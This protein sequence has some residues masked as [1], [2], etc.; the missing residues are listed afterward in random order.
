MAATPKILFQ[1]GASNV[2]FTDRRDFYPEAEVYEYW[3]NTT[4]FLTWISMIERKQTPDTLFKIFEDSPTFQNQYFYNNSATVTAD[5]AATQSSAIAVDNITNLTQAGTVDA[6]MVGLLCEVWD[7]TGT[8]KKGQC[9]IS[10]VGSGTVYIKTTKALAIA[11]VDNDIFRVIGTVRGELSVAGESYFNE[12]TVAWNSTHFLS[13]PVEITGKL[14]RETKLRGF[15]NELG[16]LR[17]KKFKE[18]KMQVQNGFLKSS[19]FVG[20]NLGGSDTFSEASLGTITDSASNTSSVRTTYGYIPIL[21]DYGITW[22]GGGAMNANTN[23]FKIPIASL[24]FPVFCDMSKIIHDKREQSVIPGFCGY[25]F[26]GEIAKALADKKFGFLGKVELENQK[27]N[28]LGW[29]VRN[30]FTPFGTIQLIMTKAFANEYEY[31]CVLPNEQA[32]GIREYEPWQYL[33][34][35]KTDNNYTGVKDV[36]NYDAGLQM[37]LLKTHHMIQFIV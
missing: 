7:S 10:A 5:N 20:T 25:G 19:S 28:S 32:I 18:M 21:E 29:D 6:S 16:R 11:T 33:T 14:Y 13:L 26:V 9:Y 8:T 23:I 35:I 17:E 30:L 36:I 34:N 22:S 2:L 1:G 15:A 12:L 4:Q 24:D 3:K 27:V 37:N 31:T